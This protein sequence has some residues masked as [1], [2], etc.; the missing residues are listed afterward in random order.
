[1]AGVDDFLRQFFGPLTLV[2]PA[3]IVS[4]QAWDSAPA[5]PALVW[6][7]RLHSDGSAEPLPVDT[8]FEF[9]HDGRL[10]LNFNLTD[11]R[12]RA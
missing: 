1:M 2:E 5:I 7:F 3:N 11:V 12:A 10:W 8:S 4:P 6:A 9:N